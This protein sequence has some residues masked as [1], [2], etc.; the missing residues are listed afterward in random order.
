M[1][2]AMKKARGT[3]R[4]DRV[5]KNEMTPPVGA[6]EMPDWLDE[7]ARAIWSRTA[8]MLE[9]LGVLSEMDRIAL[10]SYCSA[11]SL[12]IQATRQVNRE[13]LMKRATKGSLFGPK[14]NP[15]IKIAQG[16]RAQALR[17]G[18]EFGLTPA[19]RSR[20]STAPAPAKGD[21]AEEFIFG[22][23]KLVKPSES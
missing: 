15:L 17:I 10:A 3:Y 21:E 9:E 13:G 6:P 1:P 7:E 22:K 5:A 16:A 11:A 2:S 8:P 23:P 19:A 20:I 4:R 18:A 14:V 12:A